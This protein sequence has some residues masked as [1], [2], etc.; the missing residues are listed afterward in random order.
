[1]ALIRYIGLKAVKEDNVARTGIT[2]VGNEVKEVPDKVASQ[3]LAHPAVW[4]RAEVEELAAIDSEL[5]EAAEIEALEVARQDLSD[6][7]LDAR[8]AAAVAPAK[9]PYHKKSKG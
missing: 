3:L 9:R 6:D 1:M 7:E 8:L 4:A 2:W 5:P